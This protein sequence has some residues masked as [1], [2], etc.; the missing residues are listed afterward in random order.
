MTA[1]GLQLR[2]RDLAK[3]GLLILNEGRWKG[4]QVLPPSWIAQMLTVRRQPNAEQG[5][6]YLIWHG[7]F[8]GAGGTNGAWYMLGNGVNE[9]LILKELD[10]VVVITRTDYDRPGAFS[11]TRR[12]LEA[13]VLAAMPCERMGN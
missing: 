3:F 9:V 13:Y 5:Y 7:D 1:S 8:A 4:Q 11:R 2:S 6:G 12:F 10:A